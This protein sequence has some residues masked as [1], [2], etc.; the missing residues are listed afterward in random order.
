M[1]ESTANN[2]KN[3]YR[4][5][6]QAFLMAVSL[7]T[8]IPVT[9]LLP[10]KWRDRT[11]GLSALW[12]PVVG[13]LLAL[14][15]VL[16]EALLPA[17]F[18]HELTAALLVFLWVLITG[19]LHLD[20]LADSVDA[21]YAGHSVLASEENLP[22]TENCPRK[23]K[24]L[25]VL[26]DPTAGP[27]AVIAL[28]FIIVF[29][30]ILVAQLLPIVGVSLFLALVLSR[31]L[32]L[33]MLVSTPYAGLNG[34]GA[35]LC[36]QTPKLWAVVICVLVALLT[37]MTLPWLITLSLSVVLFA[38]YSMWR[39]YWLRVIGGFVGDTLG[40][41]IEISEVLILLVMCF[42]VAELIL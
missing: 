6:A 5:Y 32:A 22:L 10:V 14:C 1:T 19:A 29:K 35:V 40:A 38:V 33:W 41:L 20:G 2:S 15:L 24:V 3:D 17:H 8:R 28:I 4:Q 16:F 39:N 26:K 23:E 21:M 9:F 12:Y 27:M 36:A 11:L 30:I 7:L 42:F 13:A 25:R 34:L 18:S 31:T 37:F